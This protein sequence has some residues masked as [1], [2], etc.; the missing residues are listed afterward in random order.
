MRECVSQK[1]KGCHGS[2]L[3]FWRFTNRIIITIIINEADG[4][5]QELQVVDSMD[6]TLDTERTDLVF[7]TKMMRV[8]EARVAYRDEERL[9]VKNAD[10]VTQAWNSN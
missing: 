3:T 5:T 6:K 7:V 2:L 4:K 1:Q 9:L 8:H 10:E